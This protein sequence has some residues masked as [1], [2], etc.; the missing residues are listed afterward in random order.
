[1]ITSIEKARKV[2]EFMHLAIS[3]IDEAIKKNKKIVNG[4]S[5]VE[6][7]ILNALNDI[8]EEQIDKN[9]QHGKNIEGL[10]EISIV[11]EYF[12]RGVIE[13]YEIKINNEDQQEW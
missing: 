3:F 12:L 2:K 9:D 6:K 4:F 8:F 10:Y 7:T 11:F 5:S 13:K 1:M